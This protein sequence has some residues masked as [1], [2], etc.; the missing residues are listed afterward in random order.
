MGWHAPAFSTTNID[1][2]ALDVLAELLFSERAPLYKRLVI[3]EQKV[4][5]ISGSNDTHIDPHLFTVLARVKKPE[6]LA[7]VEKA[8]DDELARVGREGVDDKT[9]KDVLSNVRYSFAGRLSTA[10]RV[11]TTAAQFIALGRDIEAINA[12]LRSVPAGHQRGRAAGGAQLLQAEQPHGGHPD[13]RCTT[14]G[15]A[16]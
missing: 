9:L 15:G 10:D 11:A 4:Q 2:Q 16:P 13:R 12:L 7:Y 1:L 8:I 14:T 6:D 3:K 5:S